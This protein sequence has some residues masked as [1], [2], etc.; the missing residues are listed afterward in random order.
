[1]YAQKKVVINLE[2]QTEGPQ[3][4]KH[5]YGHFA[6]HLGRCIYGGF[7]VGDDETT[8]PNTDGV[9]NDIVDAL[10]E[11]QIPNLRWP[12]GCFADTYHWQD[13]IGPK[14]QRPTIVNRW[15]GDVTEDN[16]FGTHE[17][18]NMC[19]LLDTEPYLSG[20]V[21]SGTVK[22]F[23]DWMQYVN[24]DGVSP[25][26]D[27]RRENGREDAWG[28]RY[29]GVGNEAW[30][31]GGN[32][33]AEYYANVYRQFATYMGGWTNDGKVMRIASGASSNDYNWTE[34]LM[35]N[36]PNRL[37]DG[38][39]LHHYSV[40][41]WGAKGP[42]VDFNEEQYFTILQRAYEMEELVTKH[43]AIM[44]KY[45]PEGKIDLI[46]DEWGGWYEVEE[47]TNPG[48]LYQQNTM[49]DAMIAGMT[50]NI[51][52]NH[53][54]RVKMANLAQAVNVLQ[55]VILT[56]EEKM[57]LT[58]TYHVMRMYTA[59]HDATLIPMEIENVSYKRGEAELPAISASASVDKDGKKHISLVN[60]DSKEA[61]TISIPLAGLKK[62]AVTGEI[63]VSD[64]IQN[65]NSFDEPNKVIPTV[66]KDYKVKGDQLEV[67]LPAVSVV[68]LEV[69]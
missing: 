10:K 2:T 56:D 53:A 55:A 34:V 62:S 68:M 58:P 33:T 7:Y 69:K 39:A 24:N 8:I 67:T 46:V 37:I 45:D 59:H 22:E 40:I 19:E 43:V 1:M 36:I 28:V 63:L 25:M 49:R 20:N 4:S 3:I 52:N 47:G 29:W 51:F 16:S 6:E 27:L 44:D 31:C 15:W 26:S 57:I 13:G 12:G 66:F 14:D 42:A 9:R 18:L 23:A 35:K 54:D 38:I 21:G 64:K 50:L 30:G 65:H 60:I 61:Y 32:M 48:F 5:I 11:L 41:D 17:F